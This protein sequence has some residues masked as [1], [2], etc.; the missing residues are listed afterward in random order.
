M[1][2]PPSCTAGAVDLN[3]EVDEVLTHK[4]MWGLLKQ[5][6]IPADRD[7]Q[8]P[9][10]KGATTLKLQLGL[11]GRL[12]SP[13]TLSKDSQRMPVLTARVFGWLHHWRHRGMGGTGLSIVSYRSIAVLVQ[14]LYLTTI[15]S[16]YF[17]G[18]SSRPKRTKATQATAGYQLLAVSCWPSQRKVV[19]TAVLWIRKRR[20]GTTT[21]KMQ[22]SFRAHCDRKTRRSDPEV[23]QQHVVLQ[24]PR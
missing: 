23:V 24:K 21:T 6:S 2:K 4:D 17:P 1:S 12:M 9:A 16:L 20:H 5:V 7:P 14:S 3:K 18:C 11:A 13:P 15:S 10:L 8:A 19:H 22:F